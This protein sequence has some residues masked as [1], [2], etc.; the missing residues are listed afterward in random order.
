VPAYVIVE[1]EALDAAAVEK[2]RAM[3]TPTVAK[4]GGRY[5]ARGAATEAFEGEP[6]SRR[7]TIIEFPDADAARQWYRS[8]E[9]AEALAVG[10]NAFRRRMILAPGL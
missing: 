6:S 9:Y 8:P 2:Y 3:A 1:S 4:H 10:K 7:V 5:V